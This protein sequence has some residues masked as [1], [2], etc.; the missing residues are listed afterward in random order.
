MKKYLIGIPRQSVAQQ[1][2]LDA[3]LI[4]NGSPEHCESKPEYLMEQVK[5]EYVLTDIEQRSLDPL[6]IVTESPEDSPKPER[7]HV[8]R[9]SGAFRFMKPVYVGD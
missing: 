3:C 8:R 9:G 5:K 6:S 1:E 4:V 7:H 2:P